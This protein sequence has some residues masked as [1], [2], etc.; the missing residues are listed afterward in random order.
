[1]PADEKNIMVTLAVGDVVEVK[2]GG[3]L[4]TYYGEDCIINEFGAPE[5][6]LKFQWFVGDILHEGHFPAESICKVK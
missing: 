6:R 1:M 4:M 3:P 2:S 5:T